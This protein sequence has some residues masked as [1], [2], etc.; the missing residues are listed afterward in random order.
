M[1]WCLDIFQ[2][3]II[4]RHFVHANA[5]TGASQIGTDNTTDTNNYQIL[6]LRNDL[7]YNVG[8]GMRVTLP[9]VLKRSKIQQRDQSLIE[10]TKLEHEM[11][12]QD[13]ASEVALSYDNYLMAL[14]A[15]KT[16]SANLEAHTLAYEVADQTFKAGKLQVTEYSLIVARKV[17]AQ[18]EFEKA[19]SLARYHLHQ[20]Q[21][22][23]GPF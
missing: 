14:D 23:C 2:Y 12:E 5:F 8:V 21:V 4:Q 1:F 9:D 13:I 3:S 7:A 6:T 11:F 16:R 17:T 20:L 15:I 19:Q 10:K 18:E 22:L